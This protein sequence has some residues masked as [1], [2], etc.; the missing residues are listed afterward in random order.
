MPYNGLY[1][2]MEVYAKFV[3]IYEQEIKT[4]KR[5]PLFDERFP[6]ANIIF[7]V[8]LSDAVKHTTKNKMR[9][10]QKKQRKDATLLFTKNS[11]LVIDFCRHFRNSFAHALM[12]KQGN[13]LY[14]PDF[15]FKKDKNTKERI[16]EITSKGYVNSTLAYQF[17]QEIIKEYEHNL[18]LQ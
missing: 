1:N 9:K 14:I 5:V 11:G 6:E 4:M 16:K 3:F 18:K 10:P 2:E 8:E 12:Y 15:S 17:I 7:S 13:K